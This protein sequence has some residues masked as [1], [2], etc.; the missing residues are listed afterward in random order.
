MTDLTQG[1]TMTPTVML[2]GH[3]DTWS[4]GDL[5]VPEQLFSMLAK[6]NECHDN[7]SEEKK[8]RRWHHI[9]KPLL[10]SLGFKMVSKD[11]SEWNPQSGVTYYQ[12]FFAKLDSLQKKYRVPDPSL[13]V[14][15]ELVHY[16]AHQKDIEQALKQWEEHATIGNHYIDGTGMCVPGRLE[17]FQQP[18]RHA[19]ND[20]TSGVALAMARCQTFQLQGAIE[21]IDDWTDHT[22]YMEASIERL[23][24]WNRPRK[25]NNIEMASTYV[26]RTPFTFIKSAS[27]TRKNDV[28]TNSQE[29][30]TK[31]KKVE[32]IVSL[33]DSASST[34]LGD[35]TM[36]TS[37]GEVLA[38]RGGSSGEQLTLNT[39]D[40]LD[41]QRDP[42]D[43]NEPS[44]VD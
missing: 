29:S 22:S 28:L 15:H 17:Q 14:N 40:V 9:V 42:L 39:N 41:L 31:R 38:P 21:V 33:L 10:E 5:M 8:D 20:N 30:D 3:W 7:M 24:I 34:G 13:F 32:D 44:P 19:V 16:I 2:E 23:T 35:V 43:R 18:S 25:N 12:D 11:G 26:G 36:G 37:S 6:D 4:Y 1:A 27:P